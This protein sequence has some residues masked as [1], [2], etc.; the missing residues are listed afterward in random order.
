ML[1][2]PIVTSLSKTYIGLG[3]NIEPRLEYLRS[4]VKALQ[5]IG[6]IRRV[7]S[8][9]ETAPVGGVA[10]PDFLNAVVELYTSLGPL[11]LWQALK[12]LEKKLGRQVRPRW[13]EREID[14]DLLFF[15][16][17]ILE[18]PELT[19]PHPELHRRAFVLVPMNELDPNFEHPVLHKS[20][21]NLLN[22]VDIK[23]VKR[24]ELSIAK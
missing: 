2:E 21:L 23:S 17:L 10:Q 15:D 20:I 8:V 18:S 9:Y 16:G 4:A 5:T 12:A 19:I 6:E 1:N 24:T 22:D 13:H 7:S 3:S 11:E 14:L